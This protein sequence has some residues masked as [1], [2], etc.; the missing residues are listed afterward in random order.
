MTTERKVLYT[1]AGVMI[2]GL[3]YALNATS[4]LN[5]TLDTLIIK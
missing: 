2:I 1:I 3:L 5:A 4:E